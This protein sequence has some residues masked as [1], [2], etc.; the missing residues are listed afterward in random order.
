MDDLDYLIEPLGSHHNRAVFS[1]GVE[2]LDVYFKRQAGQEAR[3]RIAAPF[4][5]IDKNSNTIAGYY[6]LSS[7]GI[8]L[9]DL[10]PEITKKLPKY[11]LLPATL[12]GRLAVDKNYQGKKL[13]E[14]LL[15]D[16]LYR[17]LKN[18][19][20]SMAVVVDAKDDKARTFYEHYGFI[21]FPVFS[22]RLFLTM[23]TIDKL[24]E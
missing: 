8:N 17:S 3:K 13:G 5:L 14:T 11:P 1:C 9:G 6:T 4:V 24:F 7:I 10:P 19:I 21:R 16:A 2:P 22:Y 23:T 20:A 18:E 15:L 12:L